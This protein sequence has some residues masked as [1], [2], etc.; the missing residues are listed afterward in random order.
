M[1]DETAAQEEVSLRD[2]LDLLRRRSAIIIQTL[3]AAL[4]IGIVV[5]VISSN[6]Y[7]STGQILVTP[8]SPTAA[9][10]QNASDP[11]GG[12]SNQ[13]QVHNIATQL[14][15]LMNG[16]LLSNAY[17]ASGVGPGDGRVHPAVSPHGEE[18]DIIDISVEAHKPEIA[19]AVTENMMDLYIKE[20][21]KQ[22]GGDL[23]QA[24]KY[25]EQQLQESNNALKDY[26][27][28]L[29]AFENSNKVPGLPGASSRARY[30]P[31][32]VRSGER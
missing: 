8:N 21:A 18:I 12:I 23:D 6:V 4:V 14:V 1:Q 29:Q 11:L 5:A 9:V 28:K 25:A 19:Q 27:L 20:E 10:I 32:R 31:C 2:Y 24:I 13:S 30:Q 15:V 16:D 17:K 26:S 7:S 22:R 3:V